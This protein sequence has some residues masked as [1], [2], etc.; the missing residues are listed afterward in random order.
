MAFEEA[1][2][3]T[4]EHEGCYSNSKK[5]RGGETYKGI[6]R[7]YHPKW[8]GWRII[9]EAKEKFGG[10]DALKKCD[11]IPVLGQRAQ[12]VLEAL[13]KE[14]YKT[15]F[16]DAINATAISVVAPRVAEYAFDAQVN[17]TD[18]TNGAK[19]LQEALNEFGAK[20]K[21]DGKIGP[22]TLKALG[23]I[24]EDYGEDMLLDTMKKLRAIHYAKE[25]RRNPTQAVH[26][27]GWLKRAL[28]I[29]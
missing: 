19:L 22:L 24:V 23:E 12:R 6:S 14:F 28:E 7:R 29:A 11:V 2:F 21:V 27:V 9:D 26:L 25:V 10:I 8:P 20:L 15:H 16:W 5:D 3:K 4:M 13:V 17:P 18:R 1:F